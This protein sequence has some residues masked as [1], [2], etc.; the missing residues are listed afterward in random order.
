M[1]A[2]FFHEVFADML[3]MDFRFVQLRFAGV[4]HADKH[5]GANVAP[6]VPLHFLG[7]LF[8]QLIQLLL[9]LCQRVFPIAAP[10]VDQVD[11][12]LDHLRLFQR[13]ARHVHDDVADVFA[14]AVGRGR[15]IPK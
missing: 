13:R 10:D 3:G 8:F 1:R 9:G 14:L 11:W 12:Q 4:L 15:E 7:R 6:L 2:E 5:D